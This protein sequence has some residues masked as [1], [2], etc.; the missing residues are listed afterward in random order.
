M[1]EAHPQDRRLHLG[2]LAHYT[3]M[4]EE[5]PSQQPQ[6]TRKLDVPAAQ[7]CLKSR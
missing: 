7:E 2:P 6:V 1:E 5:R 4:Q 3:P